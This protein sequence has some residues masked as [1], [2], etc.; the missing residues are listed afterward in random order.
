MPDLEQTMKLEARFAA[1]EYLVCHL[2]A[3]MCVA[4][5]Q[6][7]LGAVDQAAKNAEMK[8]ELWTLPGVDAVLSDVAQAEL[9][10]AIDRRFAEI[11]QMVRE[12]MTR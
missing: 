4:T 5:S 1:L 10:E 11:R 12:L 7:P 9:R 6:D 8:T 2:Y 3:A